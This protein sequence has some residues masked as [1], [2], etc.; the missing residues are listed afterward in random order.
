M[1]SARMYSVILACCLAGAGCSQRGDAPPADSAGEPVSHRVQEGPVQAK[2]TLEPRQVRTSGSV[3]LTIDVTAPAEASLKAVSIDDSLPQ[4]WRIADSRHVTL[5]TSAAQRK[6]RFEFTIEPYLPGRAE[7]APFEIVCDLKGEASTSD[8][9]VVLHSISVPLEVV[10]EWPPGEQSPQPAALRGVV[11]PA[12]VPWPWWAWA[13]I[14]GGALLAAALAAFLIAR[15][16]RPSVPEPV[17]RKAHEIALAELG[18]LIADGLTE[19]GQY[20]LF[21]QRISGILRRYIEDRFGVRAPEQTTEEFL[22]AARAARFTSID[23]SDLALLEEFLNHCDM[24]KFAEHVPDPTQMN[25]TLETVRAF[26]N[27]TRSEDAIIELAPDGSA[28]RLST[29]EAVA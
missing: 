27:R 28:R 6:E 12:P 15:A 8:D 5:S 16:R 9:R 2:I 24:V 11:E 26:I 7:I 22:E 19:R 23:R 25:A 21:Y 20:K 14:G 29:E 18:R 3:E 10:S 13:G 4:D 17:R 1:R